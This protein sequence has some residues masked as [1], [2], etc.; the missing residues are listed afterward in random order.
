MVKKVINYYKCFGI[1]ELAK[2]IERYLSFSYRCITANN[3]VYRLGKKEKNSI[4]LKNKAIYIFTYHN[5]D[6]NDEKIKELIKYTNNLGFQIIYICIEKILKQKFMP[7]S[8]YKN[9]KQ[10]NI[11]SFQVKSND[12]IIFDGYCKEFEDIY[13]WVK[14]IQCKKIMIENKEMDIMLIKNIKNLIKVKKENCLN[15][16]CNT[17]FK[18]KC[19]KKFFDNI[20]IIILNYNNKEIIEKCIDSLL[21]NNYRYNYEIIVI[22]N[23]SIDGSFEMLQKKYNNIK[24]FR[25]SKN[26][27]S[28]GRNLGVDNSEKDYIVFLDSDQ[29]V[30]NPYWLDSYIEILE[31][32]TN[33]GAIGWAGGWFNRKGFAFHTFENFEYRYMPPQGLYRNDIGY[34]GSG[35]LILSKKLFKKIDGFDPKY[36]PTCYED[37]DLS[38]KIRHYGK[39]I[40][41]S[42]YLCITHNPHQTTKSGSEKHKKLIKKNGLYFVNKWKKIDAKLLKYCK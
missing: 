11:N 32:N 24:L 27:C 13:N 4:T 33:I 25:N 2:K 37:T 39:E 9:I 40:V 38:L 20:S 3:G 7:L 18:K 21:N 14:K 22:D 12:I 41:Y 8:F 28:S 10:I 19:T 31:K 26:G 16:V 30:N 6:M 34:L 29:W 5:Y 36:D 42:P 35:G 1:I 15:A 17:A 23:Q